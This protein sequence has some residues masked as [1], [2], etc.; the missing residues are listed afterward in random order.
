M[1]ADLREM[2]ENQGFSENRIDNW[3]LITYSFLAN[4]VKSVRFMSVHSSED[5][6][7][8]LFLTKIVKQFLYP[9]FG[10]MPE[11]RPFRKLKCTVYAKLL[12]ILRIP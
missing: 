8:K 10:V 6:M 7:L 11:Y 5:Q 1:V 9:F 2:Q 3:N 12:L 4:K